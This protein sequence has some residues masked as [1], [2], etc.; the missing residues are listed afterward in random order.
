ME[1]GVTWIFRTLIKVPIIIMTSFVILNIF[2]FTVSYFRI[3]G[4]SNTIQQ[5]VMD[6]N[7]IPAHE[8]ETFNN[9]LA[10]LE[11]AYLQDIKVVIDTDVDD[12]TSTPSDNI[13]PYMDDDSLIISNHKR[14]YG[15]VAD[16]GVTARYKFILP[17]QYPETLEGGQVVGYGGTASGAAGGVRGDVDT[18]RGD[19]AATQSVNKDF[20]D[21]EGTRADSFGG[22][23]TVV[24]RVIGMQYY[25]DL[26]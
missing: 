25:S 26:E 23:I 6:N 11:T 1:N 15:N 9:Y 2:A 22:N 3:V 24:N 14:Q 21:L 19:T 18:L 8:L 5:V 17:L 7:F 10:S 4:A 20:D 13:A 12:T 16:C